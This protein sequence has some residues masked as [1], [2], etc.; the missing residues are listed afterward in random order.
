MGDFDAKVGE[1]QGGDHIVGKAGFGN[2]NDW[3]CRSERSLNIQ[4]YV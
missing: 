3:V 1:K 2:R 4:Y